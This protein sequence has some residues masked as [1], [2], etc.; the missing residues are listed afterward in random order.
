MRALLLHIKHFIYETYLRLGTSV[1]AYFKKV[2][3]LSITVA[4]GATG[5]KVSPLFEKLNKQTQVL[6]DYAI[7]GGF[8][9]SLAAKLTLKP[10]DYAEVQ[11]KKDELKA[12]ENS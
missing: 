4:S 8:S 9:A 11:A 2:I 10:K 6:I 5:L 1:G 3:I 7:A 12:R